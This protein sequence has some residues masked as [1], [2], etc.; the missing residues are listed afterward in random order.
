MISAI[1]DRVHHPA[2]GVLGGLPGKPA[3]LLRGGTVP[4]NTKGRSLLG[5]GERVLVRTAGG[6]GYGAPAGREPGRVA[7]D[8]GSGLVTPEAARRDYGWSGDEA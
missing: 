2:R 4:M 1:G 6:G 3:A 5:P 7:A 8:V